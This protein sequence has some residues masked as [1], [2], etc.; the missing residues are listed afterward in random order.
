METVK[1]NIELSADEKLRRLKLA[2][3]G[4][5]YDSWKPYCVISHC[6]SGLQRMISTEYGFKCKCCGN[7]VGFNLTRLQESPLNDE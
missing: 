4:T 1:E 5:W 3:G 6:K 2:K 7:M